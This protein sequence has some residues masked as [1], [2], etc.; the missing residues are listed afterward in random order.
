MMRLFGKSLTSTALW[1]LLTTTTVAAEGSEAPE[2]PAGQEPTQAQ[3]R[4]Q[5]RAQTPAQ[6]GADD[7]SE[8][9]STQDGDEPPADPGTADQGVEVFVPSEEI[10]EDYAVSFPV[11]I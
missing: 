1:V 6:A 9:A 8:D 5:T 4:A 11:D 10:S 2:D 7:G 3:T